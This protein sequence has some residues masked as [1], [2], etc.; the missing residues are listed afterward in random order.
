MAGC[1][2]D[3]PES[4]IWY[5]SMFL[6]VG[7]AVVAATYTSYP[8]PCDSLPSPPVVSIKIDSG[9]LQKLVDAI[10]HPRDTLPRGDYSSNGGTVLSQS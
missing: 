2:G 10:K 1:C 8:T 3:I 5:L 4:F 6:L 9:D 7:F